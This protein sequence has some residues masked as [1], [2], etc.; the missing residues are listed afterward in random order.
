M[1]NAEFE[2]RTKAEVTDHRSEIGEGRNADCGMGD[3]IRDDADLM[4]T[5]GAQNCQR[6]SY[7]TCSKKL[8]P[9]R[10]GNDEVALFSQQFA[11]TGFIRISHERWTRLPY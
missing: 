8:L 10:A 3:F 7:F 9:Q 6:L 2:M 5:T 1:R 4:I 11:H